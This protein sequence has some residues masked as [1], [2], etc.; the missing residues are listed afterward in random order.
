M[1]GAEILI[2]GTVQGVGFRPFV[3]N[4][5]ARFAIS[6][7]VAN[8][9]RG[10]F[11]QAAGAE[12]SS[13]LAALE[14]EPPPLA[15]ILTIEVREAEFAAEPGQFR[16]IRSDA[17][18]KLSATIPPDIAACKDC[19]QDFTSPDNFRY[20]YPF[21]NCTNCGPRFTI[22]EGIPYD[23]QETSMRAFKMCSACQTE[24]EDPA[25]RR[26]HAQ[27]NACPACG[28]QLG[29]H[30]QN[31]QIPCDDPLAKAAAAL[32]DGK[33][34]AI[35]GLG[36]FHLAV[37]ALSAEAVQ[38]LRER[39][40]RPAKPLAV[41]AASLATARK[42]AQISREDEQLMLSPQ[43]PIVLAPKKQPFLLPENLAPGVRELGIMLPYTPLHHLL[44]CHD[45]CPELLV[46]T[47]GNLSGIP[48]CTGND[49]GV[50]KLGRVADN[51]LLHNREIVTRIDDS[52]VKNVNAKPMVY[53]RARGYVPS[54]LV[55]YWQLPQLIACGGGLKSTFC[56]ARDK[57][58]FPSQHIGDLA[59]LE[60]FEFYLESIR[61][62]KKLLNID[63]ALA[64]C[65]LHPDYM[66]SRYAQELDLP[67]YKV[68]HHHAHAAAVMAEHGISSQ[69]LAIVLDGTGYGTDQTSWGGEILQC[70]LTEFNRLG[71]L[72][73]FMLPGG[74]AAARE[75][76]RAALS[77]LHHSGISRLP[78]TLKA[79][80]GEK[81][82][83]VQA[84]L[85]NAFNSPL[86]SSCG[87]LFD[88]ISS[89][90]GICQQN[91]YEGQA[92]VELEYL[93]SQ[94]AVSNWTDELDLYMKKTAPPCGKE[95]NSAK[96]VKTVLDLIGKGT[97][98]SDVALYFH[99]M[100]IDR[101][102]KFA[103]RLAGETGIGQVVLAGGC[104]Q[105]SLLLQ[106]FIH[107]LRQRGL[108]PLT[109][110]KIPV[111]DGGISVGQAVIGGLK[112]VHSVTDESNQG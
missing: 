79:I 17:G 68:Q 76:W 97:T 108:E 33:V 48:I 91:S 24:Y 12:L 47:S 2:Q 22:V 32:K 16:I 30:D 57:Q 112:Y 74:D 80:G 83:P 23:R 103:A 98:V 42:F 49:D 58:I 10:V 77:L 35:R 105:N 75:P 65:D 5:A 51:F 104:F 27:P 8:T 34:L 31:G 13:F 56:L 45:D 109:G 92:A 11:I 44:F 54:P 43:C 39:K 86:T 6:G 14:N 82:K 73:N 21:T 59:N 69:V 9:G 93:A 95:I 3:Y 90:L 62:F 7:S 72:A 26:F 66:S 89:L 111:N 20:K 85:K 81:I 100:V 96:F 52:V 25:N 38:T 84:M 94:A 1:K 40:G 37:N 55:S 87:R 50:E 67:L 71:H 64:V 28:P 106:G 4:L 46:M 63:P 36:G 41:M 15:E 110:S 70:S 53:R 102:S 29:W 61:H 18:Q 88:G 99:F 60:S 19:Y 107:A 101:F 78:E